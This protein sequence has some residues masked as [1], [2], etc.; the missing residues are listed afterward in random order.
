MGYE[1]EAV[2]ES[3]MWAWATTF[4]G[5]HA[6]E[7]WLEPPASVF[8]PHRMPSIYH[9]RL[10]YDQHMRPFQPEGEV[11]TPLRC[12]SEKVLGSVGGDV[13]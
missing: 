4:F 6:P 8:D 5:D 10:Y 9:A 13:H 1:L 3:E 2:S 12:W 7:A 11:Y